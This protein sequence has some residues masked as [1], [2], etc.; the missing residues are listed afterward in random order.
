MNEH[1]SGHAQ[2]I[3]MMYIRTYVHKYIFIHR[4]MHEH[5]HLTTH[6]HIDVVVCV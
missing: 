4:H 2:Y 3:C 5:I 1:I 6:R